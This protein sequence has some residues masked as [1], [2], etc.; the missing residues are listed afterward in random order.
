M[1]Y[2]RNLRC[3]CPRCRTANA[4][5]ASIWIVV[6]T[7]FLLHANGVADITVTWPVI[8]IA[9]G[10]FHLIAWKTPATGHVQPRIASCCFYGVE[11]ASPQA[12]A[13]S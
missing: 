3:P 4:L 5:G 12:K 8:L 6:G 10:A 9:I 1:R 11:T 7:L 2:I 13:Q